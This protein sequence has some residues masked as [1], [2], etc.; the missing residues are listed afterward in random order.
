MKYTVARIDEDI[1]YGCEERNEDQPVMAIVTLK[2]EEG[3]E[4]R[5]RQEDQMLYDREINE[6]D[7]VILDEENKLKRVPDE[8]WTKTC[9]SQNVDIPKFTAMMEAVK[10]GKDISWV[11]PFCGGKVGRISQE[12][13]K[14][15]IGCDSC[16]MRIELE[17]N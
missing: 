16:D 6:G 7:E 8:N 9:T 12:N 4:I 5:I 15:T 2:D 1:D 3:Q 11:C 13:G 14:T 10:E 17:A